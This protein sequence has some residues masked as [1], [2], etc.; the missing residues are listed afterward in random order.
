M[1]HPEPAT[2]PALT[3]ARPAPFER[4]RALFSA[5]WVMPAI[6][7]LMFVLAVVGIYHMLRAIRPDQLWAELA[8]IPQGSLLLSVLF[9]ALSFMFMIG[10]DASALRYI[11]KRLPFRTVA[12]AS[13]TGYAFS[14]TIGM[15]LV[16][17]TSV[18]YR[19][20]VAAGLDGMDVAKI[21][22][23]C[24][25]AFG[26]GAHIVAAAGLALAPDLLAESLDMS[27]GVLRGA[28]LV[29]LGLALAAL[30]WLIPRPRVLKL[31]TWRI[32][33]PGWRLSLT[34]LGITVLDILFSVACLYVLLPADSVPFGTLVLVF[35]LAA[36]AGVASHVPAGL[37]VFEAVMLTAL[38]D[39]VPVA[40]LTAA[41]VM[42]R[43]IYY[44]LPLVL[45]SGLLVWREL[46]G[47]AAPRPEPAIAHA[48][49]PAVA[50]QPGNWATRLAPVAMSGLTFIAGIIMLVSAVI[51]VMPQRL[52]IL[53]ATVPLMV[54]EVSHMLAGLVGLALLI[55][56][57]GL[58]RRLNGAYVMTLAL[59]VVG[60][61]LNLVKGID[62]EEAIAL[63]LV[64][65]ALFASRK[66]FYRRTCMLDSPFSVSGL[67]AVAAA[68]VGMMAVT[69]FSFK[70]VDYNHLLWWQFGFDQDAA[71]ALRSTL[72]VGLGVTLL[73]LTLLLRP[74]RHVPHLPNPA[75]L[76]H[77]QAIIR[78]QDSA[79]ANLALMGDKSIMLN[80]E[81]DAF[82]MFGKRG[83]SFIALGDPVGP[84]GAGEELAWAFREMVSREG[85]RVAFYQVRAENLPIYL[86][87]GLMPLKIG[88][89]AVI[90]LT[91]FT[92]D[93]KKAEP[94]R[95]ILNR[96]A[97]A[98]L[99]FDMVPA[100]HVPGIVEELRM[101][102]DDWL[103]QRKAREKRFSLGFFDPAYVSRFDVAVLR[104]E[105]RIVAFVSILRTDTH[106]EAA[107]DLMRQVSNAPRD[108]MRFLLLKLMI[109]L[110]GAGYTRLS[111]SMAPLS[112]LESHPYAP[113]WQ[114]VGSMIYQR[115]G[116][117]YNF[118]GLREFKEQFSPDWEPRFLVTQ[119]GLN[120]A[121]ILADVAA[122][123]GGGMRGV[124]GK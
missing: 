78:T 30:V 26:L 112:G 37:G 86:D 67:A 99:E 22:A 58:Q 63:A 4:V 56:A 72:G 89:E 45:A 65:L 69:F 106:T 18:R 1:Q 10:Y 118:R 111:L 35:V 29:G 24:A 74:P 40:Q 96:G 123:V 104:H 15:A 101:V 34:Q 83:A 59:T 43:I 60:I 47:A 48:G 42:F 124:L 14:N 61:V 91:R 13:F 12:L 107:S 121:I 117:Y 64:A 79:F 33:L 82:I 50:Q 51:P 52:E 109:H 70:Q 92:L 38:H 16:S 17:G 36:A 93:G 77:A 122:L 19:I 3:E 98:G 23:F 114:R 103:V 31:W 66:A 108:A 120:P 97:R 81:G 55:L 46:K 54:V 6:T 115:G 95:Y 116:Q 28:G 21:A 11:G 76:A 9:M 100:T 41:L 32:A 62:V 71:R 75:T 49:T 85:G 90:S 94:N 68:V 7:L 53:A 39:H 87:M 113:I 102:S 2:T 88:E 20:Y 57:R 105:G 5:K 84:G 110:K 27:A 73:G 80:E 44:L 8:A 119:G 25:L